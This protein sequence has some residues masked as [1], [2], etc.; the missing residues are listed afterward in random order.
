M[1]IDLC[2]S[3]Q[4]QLYSVWHCFIFTRSTIIAKELPLSGFGFGPG[5]NAAVLDTT[6]HISSNRHWRG[7]RPREPHSQSK[8][9]TDKLEKHHL[10][11]LAFPVMVVTLGGGQRRSPWH[12]LGQRRAHGASAPRGP[13][14]RTSGCSGGPSKAVSA[15]SSPLRYDGHASSPP[16]TPSIGMTELQ[17][18]VRAVGTKKGTA[19]PQTKADFTT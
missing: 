10:G 12:N 18:P 1:N 4:A 14:S 11:S 2:L 15:R 16:T 13:R 5:S 6:E 3:T 8:A 7:V 19:Q 17:P 9:S